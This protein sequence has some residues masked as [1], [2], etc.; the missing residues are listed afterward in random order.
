MTEWINKL[1]CDIATFPPKVSLAKGQLYS[2]IPMDVVN[3]GNKYVSP[4]DFKTW[5]GSGGAKFE[6]GDTLFA[7]IT[8]CLQNGKIAQAKNLPN[9]KGFGSTEFFV[10]RGKENISDSDFIYYLAKSESFRSH[11]IGSMVGA[12]G[13]QRADAKFVGNFEINLP[14]L[15]IQKRIA[16]I[17]SAYDDLIENNSK[18]IKLLEE[19]A[20]RTYEEWFVKFRVNGEQLLMD[21][22]T[23]LPVG[24]ELKKIGDSCV[25]HGGGTPSKEINEYWD[26][27]TITWFSP[28]DLSR[29][30]SIYQL[31]SSNKITDLGLKKSSAKLL[32]SDSFMMTSRATIGLFGLIDKP[33]STNQGFINVTPLKLHHKEFLFYNFKS[34]IEEFKGYASGATFL[35]LSKSKFKALDINF[36]DEEILI[37]FNEFILPVHNQIC[38]LTQ[39]NSLLK[40]SRDILLPRLMS[41]TINLES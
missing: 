10:F 11:A 40:Q 19:I 15:N 23:G 27:G 1:F 9:G 6:N 17:L 30:N 21:D 12:S 34:R 3:E 14:P 13:R 39:Q 8:P 25:A 4:K 20:Q 5:T 36:P 32:Q 33:F 37:K 29:S 2:F 35:E 31:D 38:A 28:T 22:E 41:G 18:R 16:A 26:N 7:R 24:W